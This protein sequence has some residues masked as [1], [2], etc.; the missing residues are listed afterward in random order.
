[1]DLNQMCM[2]LQAATSAEQ[3]QRKNAE[4]TLKQVH[5]GRHVSMYSCWSCSFPLPSP[6]TGPR[7]IRCVAAPHVVRGIPLVMRARLTQWTSINA[8]YSRAS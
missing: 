3:A 6:S 5:G 2:I 8:S 4:N 1:M 7:P